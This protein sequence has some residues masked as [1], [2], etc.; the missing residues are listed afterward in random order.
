MKTV[1]VFAL[2]G[3]SGSGKS[4]RA[5]EI[6]S[7]YG[8]DYIIDDGLFIS[9]T[10]KLAGSSAKREKTRIMA[11]KRAIFFVEE[12]RLEVSES[13]KKE[14]PDKILI[15]GTSLKMIIRIVTA[16]DIP[17]PE[18]VIYIRDISTEED[19]KE[20]KKMRHDF[21][22]HI[23]PLPEIEVQKDFPFYWLNPFHS[24]I[25]KKNKK[26]EKTI[27]RPHFSNIGKLVISENV[28]HQ[29]VEQEK[30]N[31]PSLRKILRDIILIQDEGVDV[32]IELM[33]RIVNDLPLQ[34]YNFKNNLEK[35]ITETTGL[36]V[37]TLKIDIKGIDFSHE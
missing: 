28:I 27:V 2:V 1:R 30:K 35:L 25:K 29:L 8:I 5:A 16:L 7:E 31:Y 32:H 9:D 12:H 36:Q 33:V 18:K 22:Y 4:H 37:K 24:I 23:I 17:H 14:K 11:V 26:V 6:A 19:I 34:L 10:K 13:I 3:E 21:G 20:A 15:I